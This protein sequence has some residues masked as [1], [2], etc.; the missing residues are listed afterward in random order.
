[1]NGAYGR[2][3]S[4]CSTHRPVSTSARSPSRPVNS[5]ISRDLPPPASA[6]ISTVRAS[7]PA[8]SSYDSASN[9]SSVPRPA[10]TGLT[11]VG[12]PRRIA[13]IPA[14][15]AQPWAGAVNAA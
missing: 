11:T 15:P 14:G 12:M 3:A 10:N 1:V 2:L 13:A 8:A 6:P 4:V 9:R 7:P 5:L